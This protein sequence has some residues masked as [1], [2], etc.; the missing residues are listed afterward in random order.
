MASLGRYDLFYASADG[1]VVS[2]RS[3]T[4]TTDA[5]VT[6]NQERTTFTTS[7]TQRFE[8]G[9]LAKISHSTTSA[10]CR[11]IGPN[12]SGTSVTLLPLDTSSDTG[13]PIGYEF[14]SGST[15]TADETTPRSAVRLIIDLSSASEDEISYVLAAS[16]SLSC[17]SVT[18]VVHCWVH[19]SDDFDPMSGSQY[20]KSQ[21]TMNTRSGASAYEDSYQ[22]T[23]WSHHTLTCGRI[24]TF[25]VY[26]AS[27][28]ADY[29]TRA[30]NA[31]M[32]AIRVGDG[33]YIAGDGKTATEFTTGIS[34]HLS[35]SADSIPAG[36]YLLAAS[37]VVGST[38]TTAG[39]PHA[40]EVDIEDG[41][42]EYSTSEFNANASTDRYPM[43]FA[44]VITVGATN[45]LRM[46]FKRDATATGHV[47]F[48]GQ[49]AMF[50]IPLSQLAISGSDSD[51]SVGGN[52][53]V[54]DD[55][56]ATLGSSGSLTAS[57]GTIE[58]VA[59]TVGKM[60]SADHYEIR[61]EYGD[62]TTKGLHSYKLQSDD[63]YSSIAF[64][65]RSDIAATSSRTN[66]IQFRLPLESDGGRLYFRDL[67][68]TELDETPVL[69][70]RHDSDARVLVEAERATVLKHAWSAGT[71]VDYE[72]DTSTLP[73]VRD[74]SR[75]VVSQGGTKTEFSRAATTP[76]SAQEF[77]FNDAESK[78]EMN[79]FSPSTFAPADDDV[80]PIAVLPERHATSETDLVS[81]ENE[82]A[83][84]AGTKRSLA[85]E[86]RMLAVPSIS[87]AL[88]TTQGVFAA[89]GSV[90]ALQ[91]ATFDKAYLNLLHRALWQ[92]WKTKVIRGFVDV[93][94]ERADF[95]T[96]GTAIQGEPQYD[97]LRGVF[98]LSMFDRAVELLRSATTETDTTYKKGSTNEANED[99]PLPVIYGAVQQV[100][101]YR[102][103]VFTG[104]TQW[105]NY[106]LCGHA[107][108][109]VSAVRAEPGGIPLDTSDYT[110]SDAHRDAGVVG[111][112]NNAQ[113]QSG[114]D[115]AF[116]SS[117][118][119][120]D[121]VYVDCVGRT[122]SLSDSTAAPILTPGAVI[123]DLLTTYGKLSA[124]DIERSSLDML[125]RSRWDSQPPRSKRQSG[126]VSHAPMECGLLIKTGE[127]V[128]D[129]LN[130]FCEHI[131]IYFAVNRQGRFSARQPD[132]G[133][134]DSLIANPSVEESGIYPWTP[135]SYGAFAYVARSTSASWVG[136]ACISISNW[137]VADFYM[138]ARVPLPEAG[139]YCFSFMARSQGAFKLDG[140]RVEIIDPTGSATLYDAIELSADEW[141]RVTVYHEVPRAYVGETEIRVYP[142]YGSTDLAVYY[143]DA[144][145]LVRCAA[146]IDETNSQIEKVEIDPEVYNQV[147]AG[148]L[149]PA[150]GEGTL[151]LT[152]SDNELAGSTALQTEATATTPDSGSLDGPD[153]LHG[154][155]LSATGYA[156]AL[157]AYYRRPRLRMSLTLFEFDRIPELG[158][159]IAV[160]DQSFCPSGVDADPLWKIISVAFN[161]SRSVELVVEQQIDPVIDHDSA[162]L[163]P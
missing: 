132:L 145:M 94:S 102:T 113:L 96:I 5:A 76:A 146:V 21:I 126:G 62:D 74:V 108:S 139:T 43:S 148:F 140:L 130:R 154:N 13:T 98:S 33:A 160:R 117:S 103:T 42:S 59:L 39:G 92:G 83:L 12:E 50:V 7:T 60:T 20:N 45:N 125:D 142:A 149:A 114:A 67:Y 107:I 15:V 135:E 153:T 118:E 6:L 22:F 129:A 3:A 26:F 37:Y 2:N 115:P 105:N 97:S 152:F 40:A 51:S 124:N 4:A 120:P 41:S 116:S 78:L 63:P 64:F 119:P 80:Y 58:L 24:Y 100:P 159:Y 52:E 133:L 49:A 75:F 18:D 16:V 79:W 70:S 30:S 127:A 85:Y 27:E 104:P 144:F 66:E 143:L 95:E 82:P 136:D 121:V 131:G 11:V 46:R 53:P 161:G 32:V 88:T 34:D 47:T 54:A 38:D 36:N 109:S 10:I 156:A 158:E 8:V 56:W 72:Y 1:E 162:L 101:A 157:V 128:A 150:L 147:S 25:D 81:T 9:A 28:T 61:P 68:F 93:S 91:L 99:T 123:Y 151:R 29:I 141:R 14:P 86:P 65:S 112:A 71:G 35:L 69:M 55:Q 138:A 73:D 137:L 77:Q 84:P 89:S 163:S 31:R 19:R 90:G 134:G 23:G 17:E 155:L 110:A 48:I 44:G 111:V 122:T 87:S 106:R 57:G